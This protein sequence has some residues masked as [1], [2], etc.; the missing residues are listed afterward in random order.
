MV[1]IITTNMLMGEPMGDEEFGILKLFAQ[2]SIDTHGTSDVDMHTIRL[3]RQVLSLRGLEDLHG[4]AEYTFFKDDELT[5]LGSD[6]ISNSKT[7]R[8]ESSKSTVRLIVEI[9]RLKRE[10]V[11]I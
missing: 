7:N 6:T 4:G 9:Q 8:S 2:R 3:V 11:T 1:E 5:K 10:Q